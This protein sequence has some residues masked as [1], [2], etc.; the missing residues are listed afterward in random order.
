[1]KHPKS[2]LISAV[3]FFA[4]AALSSAHAAVGDLIVVATDVVRVTP[5]GQ[6]STVSPGTAAAI[7]IDSR[8]TIFVSNTNTDV[9]QTIGA[10]GTRT[11]FATG[12]N[13]I[14]LAFGSNGL[15]YA[16]TFNEILVFSPDGTRAIF[17]QTIRA[18][19]MAFDKTGNLY[20]AD[21]N[22]NAVFRFTPQGARSTFAT[23]ILGA[24]ELAFDEAGNLFVSTYTQ[25]QII[26]VT[27]NGAKSV[28]TTDVFQ[29]LGL[30][31]G[32]DGLLYVANSGAGTIRRYQPSGGN[33]TVYASNIPSPEDIVFERPSGLALNISTRL[34]V[35]PG[36]NALIGGF[37]VTGTENKRII[38]RALGRSLSQSGVAG[39]LQD[40]VLEFYN[41]AGALVIAIDDWQDNNQRGVIEATGIPPRDDREAAG[42]FT[43]A[44][45]AYTAAV[46]G[47]NGTSGVGL[48]EVYDYN[49]AARSQLANISTRG[50]V[51]TGEDVMIAG[52]ILGGN[53]ARVVI[54]ALGPSLTQA[55]VPGA[56][57]DPTLS[58]RNADGAEIAASNDWREQ[59]AE[60]QATGVPPSDDRESA[61]VTTLGPGS[62][63]AIV[64]GAAGGT[65]VA[66][67]EVYN[68][69]R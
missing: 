58:L 7:A 44:P 68:L 53:G 25:N 37:I 31:F 15:L 65:G 42:V 24:T 23:N 36:A 10:N 11:T 19:G 28:F 6:R 63:T 22:A 69:N 57:S 33:G 16:G 2:L 14:S 66:L 50:R 21:S 39:T 41:S 62:Y 30:A 13:A 60:V 56:L 8:G 59:Q 35:E 26:K 51:D 4:A 45:G 47:K 12:V 29:P 48:V 1:M 9:I 27:P 17:A 38:V 55:G 3:A 43:V 67:V 64:A 18:N 54:R 40:P 46:R 49:Q 61:L 34:R 5:A 52:F 20:V 32:P